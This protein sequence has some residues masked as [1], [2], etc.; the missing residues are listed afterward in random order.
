MVEARLDASRAQ[1]E[2]LQQRIRGLEARIGMFEVNASANANDP[3]IDA[4][5]LLAD[6][7]DGSSVDPRE[8]P[9][10]TTSSGSFERV[11]PEPRR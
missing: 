5:Q 8:P 10:E 11:E 3:L 7:D 1:I 6:E 4:L 9:T 2:E